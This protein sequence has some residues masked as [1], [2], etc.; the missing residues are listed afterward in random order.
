VQEGASLATAL[1]Q[2]AAASRWDAA[3]RGAAQSLS[4]ATLRHLGAARALLSTLHS[5]GVRPPLLRDLLHTALVLLLPEA[6]VRYAAHTVVDQTVEAC[7]RTPPLRHAAGFAN[8]VLRRFVASPELHD[9][10]RKTSLEAR[11]NHPL[12]WIQT[13][14]QTYPA[15]WEAMLDVAQRP[16]TM[17]LR[18]NTRRISRADYLAALHASGLHAVV[19]ADPLLDQA[20]MLRQ[21]VP[22]DRLPGFAAG[23]VSVQD[24]AAQYAAPVLDL[25]PGQRVLDACAAPGGKTAHLLE[26]ANCAVLALDKDAQ[27]LAR[28]DDTLQRLGLRAQTRVADA[29]Q[30]ATWWDGQRFDRIL[31]DAPCSAS[32]IS[33]RHPDIRWLRRASDIPALAATQTALLDALWPLLRPGGKLLYATCSVFP[34]EGAEQAEAFLA[35]HADAIAS[36]APGQL[37]PQ[38]PADSMEGSADGVTAAHAQDGFFYA[39]FTKCA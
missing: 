13:L 34:Q 22:V 14:Q 24:A 36:P 19:P 3:Q 27:R 17:T 18:V 31:L 11:W 33:R 30:P 4:F 25:R 26:R 7:K 38:E 6:P 15:Q 16:A 5:K 12:W 23:W 37:L 28:V 32:G 1:P 9:V 35:R 21:P 29:A 2:A 10:V 39:L 8:A 20:L